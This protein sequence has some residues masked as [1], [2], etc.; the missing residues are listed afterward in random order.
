[1]DKR[2]LARMGGG[3]PV[4]H[5]VSGADRCSYSLMAVLRRSIGYVGCVGLDLL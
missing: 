5:S 1:M 3:Y 4:P 2:V